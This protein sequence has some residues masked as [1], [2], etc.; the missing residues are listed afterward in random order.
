MKEGPGRASPGPSRAQRGG[1][2]TGRDRGGRP[3]PG[4]TLLR[5]IDSGGIVSCRE[6]G[7]IAQKEGGI[8]VRNC[9]AK[10]LNLPVGPING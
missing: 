7:C 8:Y 6:A 5:I 4:S 2:A 1:E 9:V 10:P 3:D